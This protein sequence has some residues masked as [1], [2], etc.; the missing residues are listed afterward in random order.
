MAYCCLRS[1]PGDDHSRVSSKAEFKFFNI[2]YFPCFYRLFSRGCLKWRIL[3][4]FRAISLHLACGFAAVSGFLA[5]FWHSMNCKVLTSNIP[6]IFLGTNFNE[7]NH[8][9]N[10]FYS[11][12][13]SLFKGMTIDNQTQTCLLHE[14]A[15]EQHIDILPAGFWHCIGGGR[16]FILRQPNGFL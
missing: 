13:L 7:N 15:K 3:W 6:F 11:D 4:R 1:F 2:F 9:V 10:L 14:H 12:M 16:A 8:G 5:A